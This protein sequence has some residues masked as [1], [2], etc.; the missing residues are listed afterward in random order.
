[1]HRK[2][3]RKAENSRIIPT[4]HM[5]RHPHYQHPPHQSDTFVTADEPSLMYP[6]HPESIIYITV[7]SRC[8]IRYGVDKWGN[9]I[10][11]LL[12]DLFFMLIYDLNDTGLGFGFLLA[13]FNHIQYLW[14]SQASLLFPR[15]QRWSISM[16]GTTVW[17]SG[18][19][20][21]TQFQFFA[22]LYPKPYLL[23]LG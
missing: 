10:Y 14:Q 6:C 15:P 17:E 11:P 20:A 22:F 12:S 2:T 21:R 9:D 7:H 5:H 18:I 19:Y 4:P 23:D 1:M 13:P 3:E 16:E 8:C